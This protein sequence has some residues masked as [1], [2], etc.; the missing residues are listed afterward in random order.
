M[1]KGRIAALAFAVVIGVIAYK[2]Q[3]KKKSR[4]GWPRREKSF[5]SVN[6]LGMEKW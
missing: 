5:Y 3:P 4:G 2:S 1:V 6:P